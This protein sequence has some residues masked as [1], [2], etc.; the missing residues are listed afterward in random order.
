M[1]K[2]EDPTGNVLDQYTDRFY[3][4]LGGRMKAFNDN[5]SPIIF[6]II[7][8]AILFVLI[9][10]A[11][12]VGIGWAID[13]L[14]GG[15]F[16][17]SYMLFKAMIIVLVFTFALGLL[18]Y[19]KSREP[20]LV[21][22]LLMISFVLT[23]LATSMLGVVTNSCL[24]DLQ[25]DNVKYISAMSL[26]TGLSIASYVL[27]RVLNRASPLFGI[28]YLAVSIW[29]SLIWIWQAGRSTTGINPT[30]DAVRGVFLL[31]FSILWLVIF[32]M[33][34]LKTVEPAKPDRWGT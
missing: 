29:E 31:L 4:M 8:I 26:V 22:M 23:I 19:L 9:M 11:L 30:A 18:F 5:P 12:V 1:N 34:S 2:T 32:G 17:L 24:T 3:N 6:W 16:N 10:P 21:Y 27:L 28:A 33:N 20:S 14:G 15:K 7:G 25:C 13:L